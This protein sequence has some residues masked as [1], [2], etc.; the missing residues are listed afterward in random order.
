MIILVVVLKLVLLEFVLLELVLL[1]LTFFALLA[2]L[3]IIIIVIVSLVAFIVI[4]VT[5][6][7]FNTCNYHVE[8]GGKN[9]NFHLSYPST[10]NNTWGNHSWNTGDGWSNLA[11][12][13]DPETLAVN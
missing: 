5:V 12:N 2:L 11:T 9:W 1:L 10:T 7:V 6:R 8:C 3:T 13:D 4:Q